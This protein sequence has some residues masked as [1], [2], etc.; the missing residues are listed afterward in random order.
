M[1]PAETLTTLTS[2][3]AGGG[4]LTHS[5]PMSY[6]LE[7][8]KKSLGKKDL[9]GSWDDHYKWSTRSDKER[10]LVY[11]VTYMWNLKRQYKWTY[12]QNRNRLTGIES[13]LM[14]T[15]RENEGGIH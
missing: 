4:S 12:L 5:W 13:K 10:Q 1:C 2:P 15:K 8:F 6:E 3:A 11:D 14:V 9:A 7:T